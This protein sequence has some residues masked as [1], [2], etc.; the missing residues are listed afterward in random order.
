[1]MEYPIP[2]DITVDQ[3]ADW[4]D[5]QRSSFREPYS[6]TTSFDLP[7]PSDKLFLLSR[8]ASGGSVTIVQSSDLAEEDGV[9][10]VEVVARYRYA[11]ALDYVRVCLIARDGDENGVGIFVSCSILSSIVHST[12]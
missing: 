3:C 4:S 6:S 7:F 10:K 1:M 11:S 2:P 8:G 5:V 12:S 9:V